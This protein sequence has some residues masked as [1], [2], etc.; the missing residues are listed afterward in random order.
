MINAKFLR[1]PPVKDDSI[2]YCKL[3]ALLLIRK[4]INFTNK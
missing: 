1:N 4:T 2:S 3:E